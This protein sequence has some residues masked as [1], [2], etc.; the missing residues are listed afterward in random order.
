M[1]TGI[2]MARRCAAA[3]LLATAGARAADEKAADEGVETL[4][5]RNVRQLDE[6]MLILERLQQLKVRELPDDVTRSM[7]SGAEP[8]PPPVEVRVWIHLRDAAQ[9]G[10]VAAVLAAL[11]GAEGIAAEVPPAQ[12]VSFGPARTQ[13]RFFK[14][15]DRQVAPVVAEA[16]VRALGEVDVVD[17]TARY[18][19][20]GWI[21]PGHLEL[22]LGPGAG[23]G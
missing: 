18:Q 23:G 11:N 12:T 10:A 3:V 15:A 14:E 6:R 20:I 5:D 4:I 13:L 9:A 21:D 2:W 17:M 16:L 1:T 7:Q 8:A 22:W 19:M